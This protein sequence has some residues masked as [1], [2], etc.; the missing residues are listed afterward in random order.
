MMIDPH[1]NAPAELIGVEIAGDGDQRRAI[2]V[3]AADAGC[4]I[5]RARS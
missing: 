2:Q 1:L 3:R 4:Q 5:G